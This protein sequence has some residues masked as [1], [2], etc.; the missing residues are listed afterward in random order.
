MTNTSPV[1]VYFA[2]QQQADTRRK[3]FNALI[4]KNAR[5]V[6][7]HIAK[8]TKMFGDT[9]V[10]HYISADNC[11]KELRVTLQV[12]SLPSFKDSKLENVLAYL[13]EEFLSAD[14]TK[15]WPASL[16]R[17]YGFYNAVGTAPDLEKITIRFIIDANVSSDSK[18]CRRVV[19]GVTERTYEETQYKI[20]CD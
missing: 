13:H 17:E 8:V 1:E 5:M 19:T 15:D 16:S 11:S 2:R 20:I 7:K 10:R 18:T 3:N 6:N 4:R 14:D 12:F 9:D